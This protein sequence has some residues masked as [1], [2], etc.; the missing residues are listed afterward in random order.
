MPGDFCGDC[1]QQFV[2]DAEASSGVCPHCGTLQDPSQNVLAA[3]LDGS[4]GD[5]NQVRYEHVAASSSNA[6]RPTTLKSIRNSDR[7]WDLPGQGKAAYAERAKVSSFVC[8]VLKLI[9]SLFPLF[10]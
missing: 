8:S 7:G 4:V 2:W 6:S 5:E 9:C 1:G 3:Y 10:T